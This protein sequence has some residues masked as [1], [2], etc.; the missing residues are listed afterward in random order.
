[1][2]KKPLRDRLIQRLTGLVGYLL[3]LFASLPPLAAWSGLM[4]IPFIVYLM[5]MFG[6]ISVAPPPLPDY[7]RLENIAILSVAGIG[8]LLL[9]Y[10]V[11]HLWRTKS[12]GLVSSGPYRFVRHPQYFALIVFTTMMTYP[13]VWILRNTLGIGWLTADQTL[14]L[15]YVTLFAY[16]VIA[17]IE[18]AHLLKTFGDEWIEYRGRAGFLIPLVRFKS[19]LIEGILAIAIPIVIM[20]I[21]LQL[22]VIL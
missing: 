13:S 16:V 18:E 21:L 12:G 6:N 7:A 20:Q 11:V 3:P 15:W 17:W 4:T 1:M 19:N 14:I 9:L 2:E 8:L 5:L 22:P 10:S